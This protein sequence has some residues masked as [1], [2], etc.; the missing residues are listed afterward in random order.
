MSEVIN[1]KAE[2]L[3][4][5]QAMNSEENSNTGEK[6]LEKAHPVKDFFG[7][8][9]KGAVR[10]VKSKP[11]KIIGGTILFGGALI[12]GAYYYLSKTEESRTIGAEALP[13]IGVGSEE[14]V[15]QSD[16]E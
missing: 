9:G 12:A 13:S 1:A 2:E 4:N 8:M 6:G 5:E 16:A 10:V 15:S 3:N 14:S 7:K 11:A